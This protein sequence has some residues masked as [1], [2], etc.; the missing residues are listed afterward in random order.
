MDEDPSAPPPTFPP[1][2]PTQPAQPAQPTQFDP[3]EQHPLLLPVNG[4]NLLSALYPALSDP[5]TALLGGIVAGFEP[6][7]YEPLSTEDVSAPSPYRRVLA[8]EG[9]SLVQESV[10][11]GEDVVQCPITLR[12]ISAGDQVATLPCGHVFDPEGLKRWLEQYE[13]RC[14]VCRRELP[15]QER[16]VVPELGPPPMPLSDPPAPA[17]SELSELVR[18]L[19]RLSL[20]RRQ[21]ESRERILRSLFRQGE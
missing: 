16:R 19:A 5:T 7:P 3:Y 11:T 12:D 20:S 17:P 18:G 2:P 4:S 13:A 10:Y 6:P 9:R 8:D 1:P 15:S 21:E 14:P